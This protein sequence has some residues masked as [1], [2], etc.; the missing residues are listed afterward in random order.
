MFFG[1]I[2]GAYNFI[3]RGYFQILFRVSAKNFLL[4]TFKN[5]KSYT[6]KLI[7]QYRDFYSLMY[8]NIGEN[9][10]LKPYEYGI[11]C[12]DQMQFMFWFLLS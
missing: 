3:S 6:S 5:I 9:F 4:S 2:P 8:A 7:Q 1:W 10:P 12:I 11:F